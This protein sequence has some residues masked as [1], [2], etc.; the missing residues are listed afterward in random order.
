M[1]VKCLDE[2]EA[3]SLEIVLLKDCLNY[4]MSFLNSVIMRSLSNSAMQCVLSLLH[5]G[6]NLREIVKVCDVG[7]SAV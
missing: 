6:C 4:L 3:Y 2:L 7:R 1:F 5:E